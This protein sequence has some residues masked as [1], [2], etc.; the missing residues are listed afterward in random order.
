MS[1]LLKA[2][3]LVLVTALATFQLARPVALRFMS[4]SA[5]TRRRNA[6]LAIT[7]AAFLCPDFVWFCGVSACILVFATRREPNPGA[8]FLMLVYVV[9]DFAWR[10]PM[11]GISYLMDL[12][13]DM[14]LS[15]CVMLPVAWRL[16]R[17]T[18]QPP[19]R[20]LEVVDLLLLAYLGLRA[21]FFILPEIG[22]G[23]LMEP[24]ATD[25]LRRLLESL[26]TL[27]VPYYVLSRCAASREQVQELLA[28]FCLA[29]AVMAAIG[30]FEAA[31]HWL[32]YNEMRSNWG[33]Y[34]GYI[35]RG[36][37]LRARASTS[38]P[39][40]L[41]SILAVAFG[42]WLCLREQITS[43]VV[44]L[45]GIGLYW[46][47]LLAAYSRG[48]W[49]G[50]G[51]IYFS[52]VALSR[53]R[54][55]AL[56]K[57]AAGA[58][59]VVL[60]LAMTPLGDKIGKVIPYFGGTV[61]AANIT[62]R[63]RLADRAW[64]IVAESPLL[65]DQQALAKMADLRQGQGIIDLVNGYV[66]ILLDNGFVGLSLYLSFVLLG[67][68]RAWMLSRARAQVGTELAHLAASIVACILGTLLMI[69]SDG[70]ADAQIVILTG[71]AVAVAAVGR[72][73]QAV[74]QNAAAA[75]AL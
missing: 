65:G 10:V 16:L 42:F 38:H 53:Q 48:P 8:L 51:F 62:Y 17:S 34:E 64:Q 21:V 13:F 66:D 27:F 63:E 23:V 73:Q 49:V 71:L 67:T 9:P 2:L 39:L 47:G 60:L 37:E 46:L 3:V 20:R 22:R 24:T 31:K 18:P 57:A 11:V 68:Y 41:G 43:S 19:A 44:R 52:Y 35:M 30:T 1:A 26:L 50:A 14:L 45:G 70:R 56:I 72:Q 25:N 75:R 33:E 7:V 74:V 29:G 32:L 12:D 58:A 28:T 69:T 15:L 5:F 6:W 55:S 61:D 59:L 40:A 54:L 4:A 36:D